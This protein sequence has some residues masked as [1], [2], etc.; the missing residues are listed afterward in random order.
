FSNQTAINPLNTNNPQASPNVPPGAMRSFGVLQQLKATNLGPKLGLRLADNI[1]GRAI[2]SDD[3]QNIFA[4]STSGILAIPIV[5]LNTFRIL[6][7]DQPRLLLSA[8]ICNRGVQSAPVRISNAGTG[9][10]TFQTYPPTNVGLPNVPLNQ[11]P[12]AVVTAGT[13]VAP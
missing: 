7:I 6:T 8:D 9:R 3:G 12:T 13:G 1:T 2:I 4:L 10:M 5:R 11:L